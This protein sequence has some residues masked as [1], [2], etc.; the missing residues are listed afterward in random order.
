MSVKGR[1]AHALREKRH[2]V[3]ARVVWFKH[4]IQEKNDSPWHKS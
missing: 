2:V 1:H 4:F 3:A